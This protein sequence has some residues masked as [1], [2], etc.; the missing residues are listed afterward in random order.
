LWRGSRYLLLLLVWIAVDGIAGKKRTPAKLA[1]V[2]LVANSS[3][4]GSNN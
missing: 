3:M 1:G 2:F 4:T